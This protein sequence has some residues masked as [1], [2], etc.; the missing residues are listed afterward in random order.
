M[1]IRMWE[2]EELLF[3]VIGSVIAKATMEIC[4]AVFQKA[5]NIITI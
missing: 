3:I 5:D 4:M 1:S 2:K